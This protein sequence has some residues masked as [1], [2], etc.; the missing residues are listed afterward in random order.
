MKDFEVKDQI[1]PTT[2]LVS[3]TNQKKEVKYVGSSKLHKGLILFEVNVQTHEINPALVKQVAVIDLKSVTSNRHV[4]ITKP[5]CM[6]VQAIN[7]ANALRKFKKHIE[8]H[9]AK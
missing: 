2:E 8:K 7:K 5:G 6:Y 1:T 9:F 4:V 3:P